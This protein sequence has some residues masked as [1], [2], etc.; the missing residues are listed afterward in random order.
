MGEKGVENRFLYFLEGTACISVVFIHCMFPSW[1]GVFVC[2]LARFAVP[3]FFM[4]SGYYLRHA[5]MMD[6]QEKA[7][8]R[9]K[10]VHIGGV[11]AASVVLYLLWTLLRHF[12]MGG[13]Q[14]VFD[15]I[16]ALF[17][18][19]Q[20]F[21][22]LVL[23]DFTVIG[24]HL[25]FL[26]ALLYCYLLLLKFGSRALDDTACWSIPLLLG[27]HVFGR[28]A[29]AL[30]EIDSFLGIPVYIWFRNWLF[31]A[32]PFFIAGRWIYR[33]QDRLLVWFQRERLLIL[34]SLGALLTTIEAILVYRTTGDD[35]ELYLGT[36]L[37]VFSLFLYAL[38]APERSGLSWIACIG[39]R[40]LLFIYIVHL[41]VAEGIGILFSL[42]GLS[43]ITLV[44]YLKPPLVLGITVVGAV[45]WDQLLR[46]RAE[47][48]EPP[49]R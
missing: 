34:L 28:L 37:M 13:R 31:M 32:L 12:L 9:K 6:Q 33:H 8:V 35:R 4:V 5:G 1:L 40:H 36:F 14:A 26:A 11:L 17:Q 46:H 27:M 3:L 49:T 39:R 30:L 23:N 47:R 38:Q 25:W 19:R 24:G 43:E 18:P 45:L 42:T 15:D 7:R 44:N 41:A 29:C 16:S 10:I 22:T 48:R 21:A 2:G 20:L